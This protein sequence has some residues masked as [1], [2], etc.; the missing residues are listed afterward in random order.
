MPSAVRPRIAL[1]AAG[2]TLAAAAPVVAAGPPASAFVPADF[3]I[4]QRIDADIAGDTR[5]DAVLVLVRRA[6]AGAPPAS[7]DGPPELA[8]RLVVLRARA[9]GGFTRIGEGRRILL[10]TRC[11]GAF[12]GARRTPVT[13]KVVRR[14]IIVEQ[15]F[16][17]RELVSQRFRLRPEGARTRLIGTDITRADRLTGISREVST[18]LLTGDRIVTVERPDGTT[19]TRRSKVRV[20]RTL[21]ESVDSART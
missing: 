2:L 9:D 11:G 3:R 20:T 7:D 21:L 19:T 5:R 15:Q 17:S 13:V 6:P 1:A 14:V 8:R 12:F 4:E 18:N 16:G 10:C